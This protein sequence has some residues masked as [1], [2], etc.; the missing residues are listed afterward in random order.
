MRII[1]WGVT[2]L[3]VSLPGIAFAQQPPTQQQSSD[4]KPED[5]LA[6]AAR[7][8]REQKKD[9]PKVKKVWDNDNLPTK[10]DEAN[11]AGDTGAQDQNAAGET[12]SAPAEASPAPESAPGDAAAEAKR[13]T[14][15]SGEIGQAKEQL[16]ALTKELDILTRKYALDQ[17][18]FYG[19]TNYSSDKQGAATLQDEKNQI[20]A[21]KQE[22]ADA[23][24]RIDDLSAKLNEP[25]SDTAKAPANP[26]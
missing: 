16:A 2:I 12:P 14:E 17:Q 8:T 23:Q 25:A 11:V 15:I 10:A 26:Q 24:K 6:A 7:R 20:D 19:K 21:K 22:I 4:Q 3:L 18:T 1:Q 5:A 9:Q 13:K